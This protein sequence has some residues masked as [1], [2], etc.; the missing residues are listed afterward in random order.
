MS[1]TASADDR[2]HEAHTRGFLHRDLMPGNVVL[3]MLAPPSDGRAR[4]VISDFTNATGK[5]EFSAVGRDIA[6][7]L[8]S[9]LPTGKFEVIDNQTTVAPLADWATPRRWGGDCAPT[10]WLT[11]RQPV[12]SG[13]AAP[14]RSTDSAEMPNDSTDAAWIQS[15]P[16]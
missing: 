16:E 15:G 4:I 10:T 3:P 11:E 14:I 13:A 7:Y 5:R 9:A 6:Q 12:S 1:S 2:L 8:R